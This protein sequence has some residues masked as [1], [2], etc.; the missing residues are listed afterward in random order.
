[1]K[2]ILACVMIGDNNVEEEMVEHHV[3]FEYEDEIEQTNTEVPIV[4]FQHLYDCMWSTVPRFN[5]DIPP[6]PDFVLIEDI[7]GAEFV[8][9]V[10]MSPS[11]NA[12]QLSE[13]SEMCQNDVDDLYLYP[14]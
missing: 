9:Y 3:E 8:R 1:M 11:T 4:D 13:G 10:T 2:S 14:M 7:T 6:I 5:V 12:L